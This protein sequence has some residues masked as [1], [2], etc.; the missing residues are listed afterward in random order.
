MTSSPPPPKTGFGRV[1]TQLAQQV[2]T[3]MGG[4]RLQ[5]KADAKVP[6]LEIRNP[7]DPTAKSPRKLVGDRYT[8]GRSSSSEIQINNELVSSH[9]LSLRRD[10][11]QGPPWLG[12]S[13]FFIKDEKSTNGLYW[14]KRRVKV[15]ELRHGDRVTLGPP[16]LL[17]VVELRYVDPPSRWFQGLK[18]GI[19]G[20]GGVVALGAALLVW[21]WQKVP[22]QMLGNVE[23]PIAAYAGNGSPLQTLRSESHQELPSLKDFPPYL[24]QAVVAS[25]DT[26]FYWHFGFDPLRILGAIVINIQSGGLMEGASTVTQQIA[27]SLFPEYVGQDDS[28]GRKIR[29]IIVAIKLETWYSKDE[30]LLTYLNRVYL[31]VGYGFEDAS[32][33]YFRKSV[34]E[35]SLSEAATL[36]GIL[37][38]P[39]GFSPCEDLETARG[40]RNRVIERMVEL[41]MVTEA[42]AQTALRSAITFDAA[43]CD[44]SSNLVSPYFYG[45]IIGELDQLFGTKVT[46][47]G[48]FMVE[49]SLDR[50]L[51][52]LAETT[53]RDTI[54]NQG[55]QYGFD[56]GAIVTLNANTGSVLA[57]VGGFDYQQSQFNRATQALRQPGSTFKVFSYAAALESGVSP[58]T[59]YSCAP[60]DWEGQSYG[61]CERSGGTIDMYTA[62]AQSENAVA[63]RVAQGV[64]LGAVVQ[65]AKTMG[66]TSP[67]A[68]T[69]GLVLG[70]S[71]VTLLEL[72]GAYGVLANG[73]TFH[74]PHAINRVYDSNQCQTPGDR[75]TC[76]VSYD[77]SQLPGNKKQVIQASTAATMTQLLQ[78]VVSGGTAQGV[79]ISG[80]AGKTG[81]TNDAVDLWF[82]GY[83]PRNGWV[84]GVWLGNDDNSPTAGGSWLAAQVWGDYMRQALE[85][86]P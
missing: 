20:L 34:R 83:L 12:R 44:T 67:L 18:Y 1:M 78:G 11:P 22:V 13:P 69:P 55:D 51:Q 10:R 79:G 39:N 15:L 23:G 60:L 77:A 73:G 37:P 86:A 28:L 40:L 36:V 61:G 56:Q 66:I 24:P 41:N 54:R 14:G 7:E 68:E 29:E 6:L 47:E 46:D 31:G 3:R 8:L 2:Q 50:T 5:L 42:E 25:E 33:Q 84:T 57:L 53:L 48:N 26:R 32:Q 80:A 58:Y 21:E 27:R 45:R 4:T 19:Y 52:N 82:V 85:P 38:A 71:E 70:Q 74:A 49:T 75:Q 30:L 16:E 43:V 72:T 9:H 35:I 63:L 76:R 81:T 65:L 64:G 62:V 17:K 59:G